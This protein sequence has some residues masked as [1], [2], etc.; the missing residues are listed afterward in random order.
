METYFEEHSFNVI[1]SVSEDKT[2]WKARDEEFTERVEFMK[3]ALAQAYDEAPVR[4]RQAFQI[5]C[6]DG[7]T[8]IFAG[9]ALGITHQAVSKVIKRFKKRAMEKFTELYELQRA[10]RRGIV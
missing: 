3:R 5:V 4:E 2:L 9:E 8:T 7:H 1:E 10:K 6:L